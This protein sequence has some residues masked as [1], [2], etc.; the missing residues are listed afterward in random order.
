MSCKV[1]GSNGTCTSVPS[2]Q[3]DS[4]ATVT[5]V[6]PNACN[7]AGGCK[8]TNGQMCALGTDCVSGSCA[9]GVCCTTTCTTACMACNLGG[10]SGTCS[11]IVAGLP[12]TNPANACSGL[13]LCDGAGACKLAPGQ[14][15]MLPTDCASNVCAALVCQ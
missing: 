15:C 13:N 11:N 8:K 5:C 3:T 1:T 9:D 14:P 10:T 2:G 12:D 6:A 4:F 7:G